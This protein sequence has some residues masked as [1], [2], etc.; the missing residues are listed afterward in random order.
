AFTPAT[1]IVNERTPCD[2]VYLIMRGTARLTLHDRAGHE[3]LIAVLNRGDLFR[4]ASVQAETTCYLLQV[5]REALR[6]ML[7]IA[8]ELAAALRAIYRQRMVE[9]TLG[10]VPLFGHLS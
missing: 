8:P 9:S 3:V 5:E 2:F 7:E 4:G 1:I 6:A 10:R